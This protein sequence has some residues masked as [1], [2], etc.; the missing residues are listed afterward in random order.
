MSL[1]LCIVPKINL[2]VLGSLRELPYTFPEV[3]EEAIRWVFPAG[4]WPACIGRPQL[5][6]EDATL[7]IYFRDA[8]LG[9]FIEN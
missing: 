3:K 2:I 4:F 5:L 9:K 7:S 6:D 8:I 1:S